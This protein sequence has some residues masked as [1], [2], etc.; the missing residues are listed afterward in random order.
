MYYSFKEDSNTN[1]KGVIFWKK[2]LV[3]DKISYI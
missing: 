2:L 3:K 1:G